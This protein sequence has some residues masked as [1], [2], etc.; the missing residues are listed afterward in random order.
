MCTNTL[1][2]SGFE[3]DGI[4]IHVAFD[5]TNAD[6]YTILDS[7][8]SDFYSIFRFKKY[9]DAIDFVV[10]T[11]YQHTHSFFNF[12]RYFDNRYGEY[13]PEECISLHEMI[14]NGFPNNFPYMGKMK[15]LAN[16]LKKQPKK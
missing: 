7:W 1:T 4:K 2:T 3:Q 12:A 8:D 6:V 16:K 10:K 5:K 15:D 14:M 11:N 13:K 9:S